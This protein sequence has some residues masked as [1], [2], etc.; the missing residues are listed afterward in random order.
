M[1][2]VPMTDTIALPA[3]L[4]SGSLKSMLVELTTATAQGHVRIDASAVTH[5]SA[6]GAQM[7]LSAARSVR[8]GGGTLEISE[9]SD[10]AC[11]QLA[12]MGLTPQTL[13]EG[14]L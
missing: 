12:M 5:M 8:E 7:I 11:D 3:R 4:D 9:I 10:R 13:S 14:T 2:G 1:G 6:L